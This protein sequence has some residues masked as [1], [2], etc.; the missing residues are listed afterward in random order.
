[1]LNSSN[2]IF[3]RSRADVAQLVEQ[4]FRNSLDGEI[5]FSENSLWK[6]L[7]RDK[8]CLTRRQ[9]LRKIAHQKLTNRNLFAKFRQVGARKDPAGRKQKSK[10]AR[11]QASWWTPA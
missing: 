10:K 11:K 5:A 4:R 7:F 8:S 6:S 2:V 1:M 3:A 9:L